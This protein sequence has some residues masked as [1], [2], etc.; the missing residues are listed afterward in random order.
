VG[1]ETALGNV[2]FSAVSKFA[3]TPQFSFRPGVMV[4]RSADF[5]LPVT[6][7]FPIPG[8]G[9]IAP[10]AGLGAKFSTSGEDPASLLIIGGIDY[11]INRDLVATAALNLGLIGNFDA[12]ISVGLAYSFGQETIRTAEGLGAIGNEVGNLL[13][14]SPAKPNPAYAGVGMN[15]GTGG[16]GALGRISGAVYGKLPFSSYF[17]VR[18]AMMFSNQF[19]FLLPVTYDFNQIRI[20][21]NIRLFPYA[22]TGISFNSDKN[23]VGWLLSAGVDMPIT[24][25]FVG[26][27]GVNVNPLDTFSI[28]FL[29]GVAYSFGQF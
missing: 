1:G 22:G 10:F 23:N 12:G 29:L 6:Y 11:P 17:S 19:S 5:L 3:L 4:A 16:G 8:P 20:S 2:S 24:S 9:H 7:D 25:N 28:G 18:P 15:F 21:E 14:T 13:S 27:F 26:T